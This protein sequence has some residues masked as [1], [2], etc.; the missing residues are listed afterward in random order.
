MEIVPG[1]VLEAGAGAVLSFFPN[2]NFH[3]VTNEGFMPRDLSSAEGS[4][5]I[6][7]S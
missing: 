6:L 5:R 1:V 3:S 7:N 2:W 4:A